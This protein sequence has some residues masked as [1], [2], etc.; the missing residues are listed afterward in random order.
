MIS[1][2]LLSQKR[3]IKTL[4]N[5]FFYF[6]RRTL[7]AFA[8]FI[9]LGVDVVPVVAVLT[10]AHGVAFCCTGRY[11]IFFF[12]FCGKIFKRQKQKWLEKY[13]TD[14]EVFLKQR[15]LAVA[16]K[17]HTGRP[18]TLRTHWSSALPVVKSVHGNRWHVNRTSVWAFPLN[19]GRHCSQWHGAFAQQLV[20]E[21][22]CDSPISVD[23]L[24]TVS[25]WQLC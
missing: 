6:I 18:D 22:L 13:Q 24:T 16:A 4:T 10:L 11:L 19:S 20:V 5:L 1:L 2:K 8:T 14:S 15:H 17:T 7:G 25:V 21:A 12:Y 3:K 9:R 23:E